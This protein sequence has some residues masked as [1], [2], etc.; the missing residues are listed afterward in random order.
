M[1]FLDL[2]VVIVIAL[3]A[4]AGWH[5]GLIRTVYGLVSF[6]AAIVLAY[7]L[8]PPVSRFL[9]ELNL[10]EFFRGRIDGGLTH[11]EYSADLPIA[12]PSVVT[13]MPADFLTNLAI[14]AI[15]LVAV[16]FVVIIALSVVGA[17]LDIVSKL[18]VI[19]TLNNLG[20]LVA[21]AV[22]GAGVS[23]LVL[24][25]M[26]IFAASAGVQGLLAGSMAA[27]VIFGF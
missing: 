11:V 10:Y 6:F 15:A 21:G 16:F 20:G 23:W 5:R 7:V 17:V 12:L 9:R 4:L 24:V 27:R 26:S 3:S 22:L 19:N 8:R 14:D 25:V 1:N 2:G 18:P 13:D